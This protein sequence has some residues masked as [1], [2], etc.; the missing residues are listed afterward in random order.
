LRRQVFGWAWVRRIRH[1]LSQNPD[2][3]TAHIKA[4][5]LSDRFE[6]GRLAE[7][8]ESGIQPE[9]PDSAAWF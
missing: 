3:Q 7:Y 5:A 2:L 9:E 4:W 8:R 6:H 1:H